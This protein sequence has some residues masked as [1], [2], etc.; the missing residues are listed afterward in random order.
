MQHVQLSRA[1]KRCVVDAHVVDLES[2][3]I[4]TG[5]KVLLKPDKY[6]KI[7]VAQTIKK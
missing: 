5:S 3:C 7:I 6:I 4:V 2:L 1:L